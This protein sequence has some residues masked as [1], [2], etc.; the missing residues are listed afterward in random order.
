MPHTHIP[1]RILSTLLALGLAVPQ[2]LIALDTAAPY[3]QDFVMTAYYSP[4]PDQCCYVK[5]N[6]E[7]DKV[8]NGQGTHGADGTPVYPGMIAAPP[9]YAFGTRITLPGIGTMTVHDRGGAIQEWDEAHRLDIWMGHGEEG[10]ARALAFGVQTVRGTV[11]PPQADRP[12]E[13]FALER[14]PA[15]QERLRPLLVAGTEMNTNVLMAHPAAGDRGLS[16]RMVQEQLR[17]AGYFTHAVTGFFGPVTQES[18]AAFLRDMQLSEPSDRVTNVSAAYLSAAAHKAD[19]EFAITFID[20]SSSTSSIKA[21][22]R[23]LRFL[24]YYRGRTDGRYDDALFSAILAYQRDHG[25]VGDAM[26]PGAGRIGPLTRGVLMKQM[27]RRRIAAKAR[28]ILKHAEVERLLSE[29]G[30]LL[31]AFLAEGATGDDVRTLQQRLAALGFFPSQSVNGVFGPQT[32]ESVLRYQIARGIV[33][34]DNDTGA[35][36]VGPATLAALREE[37]VTAAVRIV[38]GQGWGA[39]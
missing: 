29:R 18:L 31:N 37:H 20:A 39:L 19:S 27:L 38:Q 35:G 9:T 5:G 11:Y 22:Q 14:F 3:E 16:V 21:A 8:L 25:L 36:I 28:R 26:S 32:K 33:H 12:E 10:L 24:G 7:A 15:P 23:L 2:T 1:H 4:L 13:S 6:Y 17:D 34:S 30:V